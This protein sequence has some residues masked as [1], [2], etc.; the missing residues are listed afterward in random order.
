MRRGPEY[1]RAWRARYETEAG[2]VSVEARHYP[3]TRLPRGHEYAQQMSR[4]RPMTM[5]ED[6]VHEWSMRLDRMPPVTVRA[7]PDGRFHT[8]GIHCPHHGMEDLA[9]AWGAQV[10]RGRTRKAD[11]DPTSEPEPDASPAP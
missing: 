11:P 2:T 4:G 1:E 6:P 5:V 10:A 8:N 7:T 3:R 9:K